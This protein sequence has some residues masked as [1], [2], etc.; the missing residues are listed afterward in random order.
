MHKLLAALAVVGL[1]SPAAATPLTQADFSAGATT[2]TFDDLSGGS[3]ITTGDII[4]TQYASQGITFVNPDDL[5]RANASPIGSAAITDS[6][7][8]VA[9][10]GQRL[11]QRTGERPEQLVF[12][13]PVTKIGMEFFTSLT[14]NI[15]LSV[16]NASNVLLDS[17]TL[18]GTNFG[19]S[20]GL[21]EGFIGLGETTDIAYAE[22]F[23]RSGQ[24]PFNFEIDNVTFEGP[25]DPIPEP[26]EL[27]VLALSLAGLGVL[28]RFRSAAA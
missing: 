17:E 13:V 12:S 6:K 10:V 14:A 20:A 3:T 21:L 19:S 9:F 15:T 8:N 27:S 4:T 25:T 28:R 23:S 5:T 16:F 1:V 11:N 18:T 24:L 26:A 2:I 22:I 7:P